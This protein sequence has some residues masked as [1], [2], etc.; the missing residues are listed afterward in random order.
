[1]N[2][3]ANK[4]KQQIVDKIKSSTNILVTV[5]KDPSVD[6]ISA[7]LGLTVLLNKLEKHTTAIFSGAFPPAITFLDPDKVFEATADSLRDFIIALDKEKADH[8][9]YKVDG[10]V[11]KIFITPYRTTITDK[12]LEFSQGDFNVELVLALGVQDQEHLDT[13]LAANGQM[14]HDVTIV[15]FS[16][17]NQES[18]LGS[19]DW[20]D[21]EASCLSEMVVSISDSLKAD[22][23]L[24]DKQ[25]ATSLLTGIVA[26]TERF[27]NIR[28][29]SRVMSVAAQLMAAGADQ[30]LIATKLQEIHEIDSL[31]N[32]SVDKVQVLE[33]ASD[34][35][36]KSDSDKP[37]DLPS[38]IFSIPHN[39]ESDDQPV[40][41]VIDELVEPVPIEQKPIVEPQGIDLPPPP[42]P[43]TV[44]LP[45]PPS[46]TLPTFSSD[47]TVTTLPT[48][49]PFASITP[50]AA[51]IDD[52]IISDPVSQKL[53]ETSEPIFGGIL[54]ATSEQAAEDSRNE[55]DEQKNKTILS[56]S[57]LVGSDSNQAGAINGVGQQES[58]QTVDIFA[59][60]PTATPTP[61]PTNAPSVG[62]PLPPPL[63][64]Y[65]TL[66]PTNTLPNLDAPFPASEST[67]TSTL[68][69]PTPESNDPSQ[70]HIPV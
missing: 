21:T 51:V 11:V 66:S 23:T 27:S 48:E 68:P 62:L 6:E 42:P 20:R 10:D 69:S 29:S 19:M 26:A 14:L 39:E 15:T 47:S 18:Q 41:E 37:K 1:M 32:A 24:L 7:A 59:E 9:R 22:K 5:S 57:Y 3:A 65:S 25:I 44:P 12:D 30:Q 55:I 52:K 49:S 36:I 8:L 4:V 53:G 50:D 70:F 43:P 28:T 38:D 35:P 46:V 31:P 45:P 40:S 61:T 67:F 60:S 17:G 13:A 33:P 64:D 34:K 16:A 54:N 58:N 2:E 56:H 63:P